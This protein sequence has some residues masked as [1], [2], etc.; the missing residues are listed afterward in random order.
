MIFWNAELLDPVSSRNA[1]ILQWVSEFVKNSSSYAL[2]LYELTPS[3]YSTF[4]STIMEKSSLHEKG[5]DLLLWMS[6][7]EHYKSVVCVISFSFLF[8]VCL[9]L[10][11]HFL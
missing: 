9:I 5:I 10:K 6:T 11:F 2:M 4:I 8:K 1:W 7:D 3:F